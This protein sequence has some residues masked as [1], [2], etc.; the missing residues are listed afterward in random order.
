MAATSTTGGRLRRLSELRPERGRVLTAYIDLDPSQFGTAPARA[1]QITSVCDAAERVAETLDDLAHDEAVAL[2]EDIRRLRDQFDPQTMGSGGIKGFAVFAC[3][4]ADLFEVIPLPH[5][6]ESR[7]VIDRSP[8][9]EPLARQDDGDRWCVVL[10]S[11]RD[12]RVFHGGRHRLEQLGNVFDDTHG[13]H[14]EGGWSQRRYEES[15]ENE[16][17]DHL[18]HVADELLVLLRRRPFDQLLIAGPEP[19]DKEFQQRLHP[20]LAERFAGTI[21]VDVETATADDVR[22]AAAPVFEQH[23]QAK[24]RDALDRLRAGLNTDGGRA[25]AGLEDTLA[26]LTEQRVE[27]LLLATGTRARGYHDPETGML[28]AHP[29]ASPTGGELEERE[30]ILEAAVEKAIAQSAEV[31]VLDPE[32]QDL[33]PHGGIAAVLRF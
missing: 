32:A 27:V 28:T 19:I 30:D 5:P 33:G 21:A 14:N 11:R 10:V 3:G 16:K 13:Q 18:D 26:A 20:Y 12:G 31:L 22:A 15:V 17:R 1:S 7:V 9:V 6:I 4:P 2:R 24:L 25:V 23:R 29:G 8:F